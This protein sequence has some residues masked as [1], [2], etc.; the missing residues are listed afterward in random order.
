MKAQF[1][2]EDVFT[3]TGRGVVVTGRLEMGSFN[4]GD[5]LTIGSKHYVIKGVEKFRK[6]FGNLPGDN[7]GILIN[8]DKEEIKRFIKEE[9]KPLSSLL[10][11]SIRSISEIRE[12]VINDILDNNK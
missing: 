11:C 3:I 5:I 7:I 10:L 4:V 12:D 6:A 1:R 8:G 9:S 2:I